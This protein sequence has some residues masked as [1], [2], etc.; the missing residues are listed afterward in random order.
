[1]DEG[2][3]YHSLNIV[4]E[5]DRRKLSNLKSQHGSWQAAWQNSCRDKKSSTNPEKE[6]RK[7][8]AF[9]VKLIL[10]EETDYP[11]LLKEIPDPPL[12]LYVKGTLPRDGDPTIAIVGTR[13]ATSDGLDIAKKFSGELTESGFKVVSGL[14]LGIDAAAH[15][16]CLEAGGQTVA[17]LGN[18]LASFYP[19]SNENLAKKILAQSGAV[20]SE[21]PPTAPVLPY[22]F[23][24]RNRIVSGLSRGTLI[25]EAPEESGSLVTARLA[26]EQ[27]R[28]VFVLP[29]SISHPNFAGSNQLIRGGAM[30]VANA[31]EIL[32]AFGF[33]DEN[34]STAGKKFE[35]E[36][37]RT[38]FKTLKGLATPASVDKIV[39]MTNLKTPDV[40]RALTF[41]ALK[42]IVKETNGEYTL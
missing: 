35:S 14:A 12:A 30:L 10:N 39:E 29:G 27:N 1:M 11:A 25:I 6:W 42:N 4:L 24:E 37:E 40:L 33:G 18:G 41:L 5:G 28:E 19:R 17:V 15:R 38:V 13:K 23:L 16:G 34:K 20:V 7:L 36:A 9:G 26:A 2:P 22:R 8:I 32:E 31:Q 3:Y 21:Y